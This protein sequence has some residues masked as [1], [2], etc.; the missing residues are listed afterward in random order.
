LSFFLPLTNTF[1]PSLPISLPSS[2]LSLP[3]SLT[4]LSLS[5]IIFFMTKGSR[6]STVL[7]FQNRDFYHYL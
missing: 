1:F 5:P 7:S 2:F 4:F 3:H 6:K